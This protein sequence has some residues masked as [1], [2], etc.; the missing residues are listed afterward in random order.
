[1]TAGVNR[2]HIL[3][4]RE[5]AEA[6]R[7]FFRDLL[8][9]R[10]VDAGHGWLIFALPPSEAA[11]HRSDGKTVAGQHSVGAHHLLGAALFL[12]CDG[13]Q[14]EIKRLET[15]KVDCTTIVEERRGI[16]TTIRLASGGHIGLYQ[17]THPT[18][19]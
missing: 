15:K 17:P 6:D 14:A 3:L 16:R 8:R 13:L 18:A 19:A 4:Y 1:M 9:W 2:A 5:D 12:M 10:H 11:V 7:V